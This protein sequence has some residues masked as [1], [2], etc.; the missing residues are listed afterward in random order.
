MCTAR[1]RKWSASSALYAYGRPCRSPQRRSH[2]P[3]ASTAASPSHAQR[4]GISAVVI[5]RVVVTGVDAPEPSHGHLVARVI[6]DVDDG[7]EEHRAAERIDGH[8]AGAD[9]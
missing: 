9:A 5:D 6:A 8:A 3:Q 7:L 2:R 1:G 4:R